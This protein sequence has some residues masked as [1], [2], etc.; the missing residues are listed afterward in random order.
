MSKDN[1][2]V[3]CGT[4]VSRGDPSTKYGGTERINSD[5]L[6]GFLQETQGEVWVYCDF[7]HSLKVSWIRGCHKTTVIKLIKGASF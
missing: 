6:C 1:Q 4:I 3:K 7:G 5:L 2:H